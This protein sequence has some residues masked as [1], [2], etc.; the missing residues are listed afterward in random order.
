MLI[1]ASAL[2]TCVAAAPSAQADPAVAG[3]FPLPAGITVGS[4]NELVAGPDGNL[5]IT[6]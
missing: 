4:N 2:A 6:T 5:W 3:E 1:A